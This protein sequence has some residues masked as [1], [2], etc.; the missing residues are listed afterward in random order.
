[1]VLLMVCHYLEMLGSTKQGY[2]YLPWTDPETVLL[3]DGKF[4]FCSSEERKDV[5]R[6]PYAWV[7]I[8]SRKPDDVYR[9]VNML[10]A[11][12]FKNFL[13]EQLERFCF[14]PHR[15]DLALIPLVTGSSFRP[16]MNPNCLKSLFLK[17]VIAYYKQE[18]KKSSISA[19]PPITSVEFVTGILEANPRSS[20]PTWG[21]EGPEVSRM[22]FNS[23]NNKAA[24]YKGYAKT[25][26]NV[27]KDNSMEKKLS[28]AIV[29]DDDCLNTKELN[30]SLLG[31]VKEFASFSNLKKVLCDEGFDDIKISYMGEFWVLLEFDSIKTKDAFHFNVG[32]GSWFSALRQA[33]NEFIAE[34]RI[35]WVEVEGFPFKFWTKNTF[36]KIATKWGRLLDVDDQDESNFH[37]KRLCLRGSMLDSR[38][39][40]RIGG[41]FFLDEGISNKMND[42][43]EVPDIDEVPETDFEEIDGLKVG[44]S[45]D[46]FGIYSL[47]NKKKSTAPKDGNDEDQSPKFPPG[48]TPDMISQKTKTN[49]DQAKSVNGDMIPR[50]PRPTLQDLSDR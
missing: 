11:N 6:Y 46:P 33:S 10:K 47:L 7:L 24:G 1:M 15:S 41:R 34:D 29:L 19:D 36:N 25:F 9:W 44:Q 18:G 45:D 38:V 23:T 20:H 13:G 30:T 49:G 12:T 17:E 26:V 42:G 27:V 16:R 22:S 39:F 5:I 31:R 28:S 40:E 2:D 3:W 8:H 35:A 43:G 50:P 4:A 37:S 14:G 48:F 21:I 32:V